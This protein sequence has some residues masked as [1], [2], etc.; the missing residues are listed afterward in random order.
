MADLMKKGLLMLMSEECYDNY[1]VEFDFL[2]G[3]QTIPKCIF[4][5]FSIISYF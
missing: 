3:K 5:N 2:D 4:D 1:F